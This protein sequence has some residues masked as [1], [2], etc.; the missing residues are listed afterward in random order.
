MAKQNKNEGKGFG[1]HNSCITNATL[2]RSRTPVP[3]KHKMKRKL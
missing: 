1:T 2:S 3:T